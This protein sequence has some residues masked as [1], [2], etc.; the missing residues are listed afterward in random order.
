[1]LL[2]LRLDSQA[3]RP[4]TVGYHFPAHSKPDCFVPIQVPPRLDPQPPRPRTVGYR[5]PARL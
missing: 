2:P 4:L 3:P 1:M 5:F